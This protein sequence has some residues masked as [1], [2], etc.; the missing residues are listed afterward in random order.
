MLD[1]IEQSL[2][3][4]VTPAPWPIGIGRDFFSA[5]GRFIAR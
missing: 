1:E 2:A 3:H 4:D 5:A